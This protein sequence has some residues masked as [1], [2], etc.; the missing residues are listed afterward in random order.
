MTPLPP[1]AMKST[2]SRT[3]NVNPV[4]ASKSAAWRRRSSR[5]RSSDMPS[6]GGQLPSGKPGVERT[7]AMLDV[8]AAWSASL[9]RGPSGSSR[10]RSLTRPVGGSKSVG[11]NG[12]SATARTLLAAPG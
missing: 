6:G 10:K 5:F 11:T 12:G 4:R 3:V 1:P 2:G 9:C 8:H 7:C